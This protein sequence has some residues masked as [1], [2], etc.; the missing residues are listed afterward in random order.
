MDEILKE[1]TS[2]ELVQI[3]KEIRGEYIAEDALIRKIAAQIYCVPIENT[4]MMQFY[5][6]MP[7]LL[8]Y[9]SCKLE[10]FIK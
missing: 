7:S 9:M 4:N 5:A 1:L 3:A 2:K 10:N 6:M 8:Y